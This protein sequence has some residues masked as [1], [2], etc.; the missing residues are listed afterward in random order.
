MLSIPLLLA[1]L[2][3]L[4]SADSAPRSISVPLTAPRTA[5]KHISPGRYLA[6]RDLNLTDF[7][8][9]V[10]YG[11]GTIGNGTFQFL[12]DTGSSD[13]FV[14]DPQCPFF[15]CSGERYS[16]SGHSLNKTVSMSYGTG[17]V[18]GYI[19]QDAVTVDGLTSRNQT[20]V[21][22]AVDTLLQESDANGIIGLAFAPVSKTN[23]TPFFD[24]LV[25]DGLVEK[26]E[27]GIYYGREDDGTGGDSEIVLGGRNP[28]KFVGDFHEV[29]VVQKYW[30][31][32]ALDEVRVG[33]KCAGGKV[34]ATRGY[35]ESMPCLDSRSRR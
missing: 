4:A 27:F 10:Y 33:G 17:E 12:F 3:S 34:N 28:E 9:A 11:N 35:G 29:P 16:R 5:G 25:A 15:Q 23:S 30:W 6:K 20:F 18:D 21:S 8:D 13:V 1:A 32:V 19:Y 7:Q 31:T 14:P 2:T 24:N 26:P 22:A